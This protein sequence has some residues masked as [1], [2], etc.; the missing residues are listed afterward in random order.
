M[1]CAKNYENASTFVKV[2]PR[3]LL[4]SFF[5]DT[6]YVCVNLPGLPHNQSIN[7]SINQAVNLFSGLSDRSH[8]EDHQSANEYDRCSKKVFRCFLKDWSVAAATTCS[9]KEFQ[10]KSSPS[11]LQSLSYPN[12]AL[13]Q[14]N[15]R[16][17]CTELCGKVA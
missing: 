5:L 15:T 12:E 2:I 17:V 6:E 8:S 9:G 1:V 10:I 14:M 11:T 7:Q 16:T 4:A 3:K 13:K